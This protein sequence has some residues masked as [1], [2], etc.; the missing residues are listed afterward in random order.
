MYTCT[1][2]HVYLYMYTR[3]C[4]YTHTHI[5]CVQYK[6]SGLCPHDPCEPPAQPWRRSRAFPKGVPHRNRAP[7]PHFTLPSSS[8]DAHIADMK[9]IT[10]AP[11]TWLPHH[12]SL[13]NGEDKST[14]SAP[15]QD[16]KPTCTIPA[17][18][19]VRVEKTCELAGHI[20]EKVIVVVVIV[21]VHARLHCD[22]LRSDH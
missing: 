14:G 8:S 12:L 18:R 10:H 5:V 7:K 16:R 4:I 9:S 1:G 13:N 2:I 17:I 3:I 22:V 15:Q 21:V 11:Q 19:L 20:F 6:L